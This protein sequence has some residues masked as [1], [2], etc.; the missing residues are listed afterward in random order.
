MNLM[1]ERDGCGGEY[2]GSENRYSGKFKHSALFEF[3]DWIQ[4]RGGNQIV[5][6]LRDEFSLMSC[7]ETVEGYRISR[8]RNK[9][10]S[11]IVPVPTWIWLDR[12]SQILYSVWLLFR[13][14]HIGFD[15]GIWNWIIFHFPFIFRSHIHF[16][17]NFISVFPC[18]LQFY[19][20]KTP[21]EKC[22]S[23]T[24]RTVI[25]EIRTGIVVFSESIIF[26]LFRS[27]HRYR[28]HRARTK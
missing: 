14:M 7:A 3:G 11:R 15:K 27:V 25:A 9:T 26:C 5:D 24:H 8:I 18:T 16:T 13:R 10:S 2:E 4:S 28:S 17:S 19:I 22:W 20:C 23:S 12:N 6:W 1:G 21:T